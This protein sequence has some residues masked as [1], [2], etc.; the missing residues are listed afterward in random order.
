MAVKMGILPG[1]ILVAAAA[2]A[3]QRQQIGLRPRG[4]KER[5]ILPQHR[6]H[7]LLEPIDAGVVAKHVVADLGC[8]HGL[9]HV[10][11]WPGDGVGSKVKA[12][13][14]HGSFQLRSDQPSCFVL[15]LHTAYAA[16]S[17]PAP[18]P[19]LAA[20]TSRGGLRATTNRPLIGAP[21]SNRNTTASKRRSSSPATTTASRVAL[22][23]C[24]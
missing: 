7:A 19:S 8:C 23:P 3:H 5:R 9:P 14:V 17:P 10:G 24:A 12:D 6:R 20:W 21:R 16:T 15:L 11:R 13:R 4:N 22:G 2:M 1:D 18:A